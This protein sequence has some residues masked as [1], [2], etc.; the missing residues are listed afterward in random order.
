MPGWHLVRGEGRLE[1]AGELG[2]A[3][4]PA[5]WRAMG[6]ATAGLVPPRDA[7][8]GDAAREGAARGNAAR[9]GAAREGAAREGA[10]REGAAREGAAREG[11]AREG[12]AREGAARGVEPALVID[13][14]RA[15]WIDGAIVALVVAVRAR[16]LA[17]GVRC[18]ITAGSEQL[19]A[20]VHLYRGEEL[21]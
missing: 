4:A 14:G 20:L 6:D 7:A 21:P 5:I 15:T 1:L 12:A 2:F 9:E 11:A 17:R 16:L 3:D 18:H 8:P 19:R 13:L 10:A